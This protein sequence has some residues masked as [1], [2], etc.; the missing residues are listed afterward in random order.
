MINLLGI[1]A[2]AI[3]IFMIV[4]VLI[5]ARKCKISRNIYEIST[6]EIEKY[7][8][9][10]IAIQPINSEIFKECSLNE[11]IKDGFS[12]MEEEDYKM[13]KGVDLNGI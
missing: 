12:I 10:S 11:V 9:S 8:E 4:M 1:L 5:F 7:V 6:E 13:L 3:I 2:L